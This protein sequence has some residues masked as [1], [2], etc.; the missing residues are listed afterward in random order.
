MKLFGT[1]GNAIRYVK[2]KVYYPS[3]F[4]LVKRKQ[5]EYV[6]EDLKNFLSKRSSA[7]SLNIEYDADVE[8]SSEEGV[9]LVRI[10][11]ITKSK[12]GDSYRVRRYDNSAS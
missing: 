10:L 1:V 2:L 11:D 4:R 9:L 12:P 6:K 3:V 7:S 8:W 5:K